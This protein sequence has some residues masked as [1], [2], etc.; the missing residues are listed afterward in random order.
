MLQ[1]ALRTVDDGARRPAGCDLLL[2]RHLLTTATVGR[3]RMSSPLVGPAVRFFNSGIESLT[4]SPRWGRFLRGS[5]TTIT[6]VGRRSGRTVSTPVGYKRTGDDVVIG[7]QFPDSKT[8]WRNF[9]D[10]G[11]PITLE[12]DGTERTGHAVATRESKN[13]ATIRVRLD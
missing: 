2:G 13:K 1:Q 4:V 5:I 10:D 3:V 8:W 6:Y 12:L 7:V 9:L 11:G